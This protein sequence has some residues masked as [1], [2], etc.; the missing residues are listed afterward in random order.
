MSRSHAQR[1]T[2]APL[3]RVLARIYQRRVTTRKPLLTLHKPIITPPRPRQYAPHDGRMWI[4]KRFASVDHRVATPSNRNSPPPRL[5][6]ARSHSCHTRRGKRW[7]TPAKRW[8]LL[9]ITLLV[10]ERHRHRCNSVANSGRQWLHGIILLS[11][12]SRHIGS[13][14]KSLMSSKFINWMT[15]MRSYIHNR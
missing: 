15:P 1:Q 14:S 3:H 9:R 2:T 10:S 11:I 12:F 4:L 7:S 6:N 13:P 8:K 5:E